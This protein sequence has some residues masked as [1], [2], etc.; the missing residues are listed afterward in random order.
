MR[1]IFEMIVNLSVMET[2]IRGRDRLHSLSSPLVHVE[3]ITRGLTRRAGRA[4]PSPLQVM[5]LF[6]IAGQR[7]FSD[8]GIAA[9]L[10]DW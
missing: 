4:T 1:G 8:S 7:R 3:N 10:P 9:Y 6:Q 2:I 5:N